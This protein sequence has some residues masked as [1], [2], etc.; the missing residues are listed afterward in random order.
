ML[1]MSHYNTH[2]TTL[3]ENILTK[4][5]LLKIDDKDSENSSKRS[6]TS[7]STKSNQGRSSIKK[8]SSKR[9]KKPTKRLGA[10]VIFKSERK[11]RMRKSSKPTKLE[12]KKNL[13]AVI[14]NIVKKLN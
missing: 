6:P 1:R 14:V 7:S 3:I 5:E 8:R 10:V 11:I 4:T 9:T 13:E 12:Q 2:D